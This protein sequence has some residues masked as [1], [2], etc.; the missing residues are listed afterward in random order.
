VFEF[1]KLF[2]HWLHIA[3]CALGYVTFAVVVLALIDEWI[4]WLTRGMSAR[5]IPKGQG[6]VPR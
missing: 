1:V 2:G 4:E 5:P 6:E 3:I